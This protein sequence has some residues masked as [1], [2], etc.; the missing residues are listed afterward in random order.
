MNGIG[1]A[2]KQ[3]QIGD[4]VRRTKWF[5]S[6]I[7]LALQVPDE[8]SKMGSPY[9]YMNQASGKLVPYNSL[10]EDLLATDWEIAN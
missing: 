10:H 3:M 5:G 2:V 1:W 8:H 4:R 9:I 6:G 7:Y